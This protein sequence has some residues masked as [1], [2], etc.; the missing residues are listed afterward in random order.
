MHQKCIRLAELKPNLGVS[1][2]KIKIPFNL[3]HFIAGEPIFCDKRSHACV[4]CKRYEF[5]WRLE[6]I[7]SYYK[8]LQIIKTSLKKDLEPENTVNSRPAVPAIPNKAPDS[9]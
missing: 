4:S 7:F 8:L 5:L 2:I 9:I 6:N 3:N 1:K